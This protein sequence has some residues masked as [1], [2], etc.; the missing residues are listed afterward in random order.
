VEERDVVTIDPL[1]MSED[2]CLRFLHSFH[3]L[4]SFKSNSVDSASDADWKISEKNE[5]EDDFCDFRL[6]PRLSHPL[7][8]S[9][10]GGRFAR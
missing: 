1:A 8:T 10:D 3:I 5:V 4:T 9:G 7:L 2:V 6:P